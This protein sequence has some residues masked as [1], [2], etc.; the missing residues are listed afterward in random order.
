MER[1]K[2]PGL[3]GFPIEFFQTFWNFVR[4]DILA[5]FKDLHGRNLDIKRLNYDIITLV[6]KVKEA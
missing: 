2:A 6:P 4:F 3:D 5:M 1:N